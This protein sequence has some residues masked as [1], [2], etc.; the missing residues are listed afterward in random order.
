M[1]G[2]DV[3]GMIL[4]AR[5][6]AYGVPAALLHT[7]GKS[8]GLHRG[9]VWHFIEKTRPPLLFIFAACPGRRSVTSLYL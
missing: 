7:R 6:F 2:D 8:F 5:L 4:G 9:G 3:H 1:P